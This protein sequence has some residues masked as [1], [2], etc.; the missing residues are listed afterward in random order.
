MRLQQQSVDVQGQS[1]SSEPE[2]SCDPTKYGTTW[3]GCA[4]VCLLWV[5][6]CSNRKYP[7]S[8][9]NSSRLGKLSADS[10]FVNMKLLKSWHFTQSHYENLPSLWG[11]KENYY[12]V[13]H[14]TLR[15]GLILILGLGQGLGKA[16]HQWD[17][18]PFC[19]YSASA[20]HLLINV[21]FQWG[22]TSPR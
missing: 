15:W 22:E 11:Q 5:R 18:L 8:T 17:S 1:Q 4:F 6:G 21:S 12:T 9:F 13:N 16:L 10:S 2:N 3:R 14:S 20:S 19:T 7:N